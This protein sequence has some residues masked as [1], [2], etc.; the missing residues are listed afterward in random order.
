MIAVH[1]LLQRRNTALSDRGAPYGQGRHGVQRTAASG[2]QCASAYKGPVR[3]RTPTK[4]ID[5]DLTSR[6]GRAWWPSGIQG[7]LSQYRFIQRQAA[8]HFRTGQHRRDW[9]GHRSGASPLRTRLG[10]GRSGIASR[11]KGRNPACVTARRRVGQWRLGWGRASVGRPRARAAPP[12]KLGRPAGR[13]LAST[14][15]PLLF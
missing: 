14:G 12:C 10:F 2:A 4:R 15:S 5:V 6:R 13:P 11:P 9:D 8:C 1:A 7:V 3:A